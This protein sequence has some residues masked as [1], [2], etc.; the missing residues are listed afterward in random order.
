MR[1]IVGV[2]A[3]GFFGCF[4]PDL[5]DGQISCEVDE[6]CPDGFVCLDSVCRNTS[7]GG[8]GDELDTPDAGNPGDPDA[9]AGL[10]LGPGPKL[11]T[12]SGGAWTAA[13]AVAFFAASAI[14]PAAVQTSFALCDTGVDIRCWADASVVT[15][16]LGA[17][18]VDTDFDEIGGS[19][20][21][22]LA[23]RFS[24]VYLNGNDWDFLFHRGKEWRGYFG[25]A[26]AMSN[27]TVNAD[28]DLFGNSGGLDPDLEDMYGGDAGAP[29]SFDE[30]VWD[31]IDTT[32]AGD[33]LHLVRADGR[34]F[35][36][37]FGGD[38]ADSGPVPQL[39]IA[40]A[41]VPVD[42]RAGFECGGDLVLH[43]VN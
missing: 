18:L 6:T 11:Y 23:P 40:G 30:I 19:G 14:D 37:L 34:R 10:P 24:S 32:A 20:L 16:D 3:W 8:K 1:V 31:Y 41:P 35:T 4:A 2:L 39:A 42:I 15:C 13:D 29:S 27:G 26:L 5:R 12:F 33:P 9:D 38:T 36:I 28:L 22:D 25:P 43:A 7:P 21:V 17:G